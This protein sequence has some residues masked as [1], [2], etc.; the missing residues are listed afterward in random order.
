MI[1]VESKA[2]EKILSLAKESEVTPQLRIFVQGGGCSGFRYG[3][4]FEED[5]NITDDDI[6]QDFSGVTIVVDPMSSNYL[7][8]ATLE[9]NDG[10][11]GS[12]FA[13]NNPNASATCGCGSSFAV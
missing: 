10:L 13:I 12:G 8:G 6:T 3:F 2:I 7:D 11:T 5:A 9:F 1:L 4:H